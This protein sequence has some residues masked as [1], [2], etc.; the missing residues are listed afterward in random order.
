M[1]EEFKSENFLRKLSIVLQ[2]VIFLPG[3]FII[4]KGEIGEKMFFL[5]DG[6]AYVLL[7]DKQTIVEVLYR[8]DY[9]GEHALFIK[10]EMPHNVQAKTFCIVNEL[11]QEKF[12]L[13]AEQYPDIKIKLK[14]KSKQS[15]LI[16]NQ[17][18]EPPEDGEVNFDF[19]SPAGE[20]GDSESKA[21]M[22]NLLIQEQAKPDNETTT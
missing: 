14:E 2:A 17:L 3:D 18:D 16:L 13:I 9:F 19:R 15:L 8:G 1:F 21:N 4:S 20:Q 6:T 7:E 22:F 10:A 5:A 11:D 12:N